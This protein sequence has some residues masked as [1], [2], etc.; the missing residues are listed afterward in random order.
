L[1][2]TCEPGLASRAAGILGTETKPIE[3]LEGEAGALLISL[4]F[5]QIIQTRR[6]ASPS[7]D[8]LN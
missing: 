2:T 1:A 6:F 5:D 3:A 8:F 7:I 4:E